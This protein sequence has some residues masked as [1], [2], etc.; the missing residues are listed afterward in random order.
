MVVLSTAPTSRLR[1]SAPWRMVHRNFLTY[2][3]NW[4]Y[5]LTGF[6]EPVLYLF[7]IGVGV[8]TAASNFGV[9]CW[10]KA[11]PHSSAVRPVTSGSVSNRCP[12]WMTPRSSGRDD[13]WAWPF[14]SWKNPD[15]SYGR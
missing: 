15:G 5:F 4:V 14:S 9:T 10:A 12:R 1:R 7:S 13:D 8:V 11:R 6:L 2:R 3:H